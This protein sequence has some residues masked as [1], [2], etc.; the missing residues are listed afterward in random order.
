MRPR[1]ARIGYYYQAMRIDQDGQPYV[2]ASAPLPRANNAPPGACTNPRR[3]GFTAF[4]RRQA[5]DGRLV[6]MVNEDGVV[7]LNRSGDGPPE[8]DRSKAAPPGS[9]TTWAQT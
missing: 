3:F 8:L 2:L 9:D 6:F 4:P 5:Y 1:H 7:W